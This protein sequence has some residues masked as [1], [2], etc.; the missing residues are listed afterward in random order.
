MNVSETSIDQDTMKLIQSCAANAAS[1]LSINPEQ[2]SPARAVGAIDQYIHDLQT[3]KTQ[4]TNEEEDPAYLFGSFWGQQICRGLGWQ[5][6]NVV[7]H[8]HSDS[9][10]VGVFSP[11]RSLA[12]YPFHFIYGC[13]ENGAP[14]TIQLAFNMLSDG[15]GIPDLPPRGYENVMDNVHHIVPRG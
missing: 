3:A 13:L 5:W 7:F 9:E 4:F 11:D 10:A 6:A 14:V 2:V 12:I 1:F 8:D 15:S